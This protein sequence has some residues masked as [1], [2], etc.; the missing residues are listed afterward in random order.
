MQGGKEQWKQG[1]AGCRAE[2]PLLQFKGD[3]FK[4]GW[5]ATRFLS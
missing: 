1:Q 2:G 3:V 5:E 4:H